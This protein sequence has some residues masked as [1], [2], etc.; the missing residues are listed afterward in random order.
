VAA[1]AAGTQVAGLCQA[2]WAAFCHEDP[3]HPPS[4]ATIRAKKGSPN[5][6]VGVVEKGAMWVTAK[7]FMNLSQDK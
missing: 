6:M 4:G 5:P 3:A 1:A 7:N 2:S